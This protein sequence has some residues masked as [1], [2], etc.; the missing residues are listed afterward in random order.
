MVFKKKKIKIVKKVSDLDLNKDNRFD[1]KDKTIAARVLATELKNVP[2][3]S[4]EVTGRIAK[5]DISLVYRKGDF[6][7]ESQ[8]KQWDEMGIKWQD[9]FE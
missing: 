4:P 5:K 6:V 3:E 9:W 7:P 8:I 2:Q 1:N